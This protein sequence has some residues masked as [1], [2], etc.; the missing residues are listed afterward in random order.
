[1]STNPIEV[2]LDAVVAEDVSHVFGITGGPVLPL[3]AALREDPRLQGILARLEQGAAFMAQ[4]Y[5]QVK[6][7]LGVCFVT[8]GPGAT[9]A[10]TGI[11]SAHVD[12]LPVLLITGE[13][14]T[15]MYD[16]GALQAGSGGYRTLDV[17]QVYGTISNY[18]AMA[19]SAEAV[20]GMVDEALEKALRGRQGVGHISL[21]TNLLQ[22]PLESAP[23]HAPVSRKKIPFSGDPA[24]IRNAV[25]LLARARHPA[26][27]AGH[28]TNKA[29]AWDSLRRL[30]EHLAIPVATTLK[31]K[32]A[33]PETHPL[34]LGVYSLSVSEDAENYI[35]SP[36]TDVICVIGSR[37]GDMETNGCNPAF[38]QGRKL[39][40]IDVDEAEIG[41]NYPI[42]LALVGDADLILSAMLA[43]AKEREQPR[44]FSG[45]PL[46]KWANSEDIQGD[47]PLLKPQALAASISEHMPED[48]L[49][50][51]D[52]GNAM[53]WSG[54]YYQCRRTGSFFVGLGY[55]SMGYAVPASIGGKAA[56]PDRPVIAL[57]GDGSFMMTGMEVNTAVQYDLPVIW[58][59]LNNGGLGMVYN[60]EKMLYGKDEF[61]LYGDRVDIA[62]LARSLGAHARKVKTLEEFNAALEEALA[63]RKPFVIDAI[64]DLEQIPA[65]VEKRVRMLNKK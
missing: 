37:L 11:A 2:V 3:F 36:D 51:S 17:T 55:A 25:E 32:G 60:G 58:V 30:A 19:E 29:R 28:G 44:H 10:V 8:S 24:Q 21:P 52:L 1:M 41:R 65:M 62:G 40:Q 47:Y 64:V 38:A 50:F 48:T 15:T 42:D 54:G 26:I 57:V 61:T 14:A 16:R 33:F 46:H 5:A 6:G 45:V 13:V 18:S 56:A 63:S 27:L 43:A 39:I 53:S 9:N 20:P 4:G 35:L 12:S 23:P 34:S 49:F 22:M 7:H 31:G 59:V